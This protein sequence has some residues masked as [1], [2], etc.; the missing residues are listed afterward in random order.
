MSQYGIG[1]AAISELFHKDGDKIEIIVSDVPGTGKKTKSHNCYLLSG[2]RAL[3]ASDEAKFS[4][5]DAVSLCK[6]LGCHDGANHAKIRSE[7]GNLVAGSKAS[8]FTLPAP[9]LRAAADL[10]KAMASAK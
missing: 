4:E 5:S 8:G 3:L 9:G 6:H 7:L 1:E 2:V 10:V